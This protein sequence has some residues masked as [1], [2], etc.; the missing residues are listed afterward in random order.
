ML[1]LQPSRGPQWRAL[2]LAY[3]WPPNGTTE[4][5]ETLPSDRPVQ[6]GYLGV[7]AKGFDTFCRLAD[8]IAPSPAAA[9]FVMVGFHNGPAHEKPHSRFV[10]VVPEQPLPRT[11]FEALTR[12]V[13]YVVWTADP[14]HYR[15]VASATFL[16]ALAFLKPGIYLRNAYIEH[17]FQRMG[18]IGYLCDSY[19]EMVETI[20]EIISSFP[21]Q[22]YLRQVE[23]IRKGRE[24]FEPGTLAVRL[25]EMTQDPLHLL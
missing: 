24:I 8:E 11:E 21:K 6:F 23:N 20:R 5:G 18:D 16:D 12:R 2:D 17:Y 14:Q 4:H 25:Q 13:T 9:E 19:G 3:P 15:L 22:R 7:S 1:R 10:P